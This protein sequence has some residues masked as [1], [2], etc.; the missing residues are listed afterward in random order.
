LL[1]TYFILGITI[2]ASWFAFNDKSLF[3]KLAY[4]P[5]L[6]KHNREWYRSFSHAFIH[7][8]FAHLFLN[9]FVLYNFGEI[10]EPIFIYHFGALGKFY[11]IIL[12]LGGILFS[13]LI[14]YSRHQDNEHY[15]SVGA[16]GAVSGIIFAA[17]ITDPSM[18]LQLILLPIPIPGFIF[19]FLY[20]TAEVL[21]D[22][23][24][25]HNIAHDAHLAG[26]VFGIVFISL[27]DIEILKNFIAYLNN[28][29]S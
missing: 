7:A 2:A 20:L 28:Y 26:A 1:I 16:S 18:R 29:F 10:L 21:L 6:V 9:M 14:A 8:D 23:F 22:K 4:S 15:V 5:F 17:V 27:L 19:A 24:S 11:F 12:Y 3:Y 25:K 13:T